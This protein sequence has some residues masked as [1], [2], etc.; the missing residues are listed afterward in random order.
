[1]SVMAVSDV[2]HG[3]LYCGISGPARFST[4]RLI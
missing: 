3:G 2:S 1:M 4:G